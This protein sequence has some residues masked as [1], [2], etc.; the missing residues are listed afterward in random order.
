MALTWDP[1][2]VRRF[3]TLL[4]LACGGW[5]QAQAL[6]CPMGLPTDSSAD[7]AVHADHAPGARTAASGA[8]AS[9]DEDPSTPHGASSCMLMIGCGATGQVAP[10][11]AGAAVEAST[12]SSRT[13]PGTARYTTAFPDHDPPPPR[14]PA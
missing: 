1:F 12:V 10:R 5:V 7:T 3:L 8:G 14:L 13:A 6:E 4:T 2:R 11:L 9:T